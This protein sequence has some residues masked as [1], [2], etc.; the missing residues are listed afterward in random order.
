MKAEGPQPLHARNANLV[1][2]VVCALLSAGCLIIP[3]DYFA[4]GSRHNITS[5]STNTLSVG[6]TTRE[7]VLLTLGEPDFVS[8]DGRRF[9]YLWSK[10]KAIWFVGGYGAAAAGEVVRSYLIEI[11]FDPCSRVS[12]VR[13]KKQ[14]GETVA[15][16]PNG[17]EKP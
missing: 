16:S 3:V 8:V 9:G 17:G 10:V 1:V 11:S 4:T 13:F 2:A 14:W 15:G 12:A 5:E 7:E 6:V